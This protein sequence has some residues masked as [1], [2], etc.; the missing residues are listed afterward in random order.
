[1]PNLARNCELIAKARKYSGIH[2]ARYLSI[3]GKLYLTDIMEHFV[4]QNAVHGVFNFYFALEMLKESHLSLI[5][6]ILRQTPQTQNLS[7]ID[8]GQ[9]F[10]DISWSL[11]VLLLLLSFNKGLNGLAQSSSHP[12]LGECLEI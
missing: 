6:Q 7:R 2:N 11:S 9:A 5:S 1:M 8:W 4:T 12:W 3:L 10:D